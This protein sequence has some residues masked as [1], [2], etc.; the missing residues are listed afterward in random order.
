MNREELITL[1]A[2]ENFTPQKRK[3]QNFLINED[4]A[5]KIV[6]FLSPNY[7]NVIEVGPGLGA[8]TDELVPLTTNLTVIEIDRGF[9]RVLKAKHPELNIIV[10]DFLKFTVPRET[11]AVISNVPYYITTKII[12]KVLLETE[13][14][15]KFVFM[16]Q[17][18]VKDRLFAAPGTK[19][20]GPLRVLIS[21]LGTIEQKLIVTAD[22]FYPV[23]HV[24]SAVFAFV[25]TKKDFPTRKFYSFLNKTFQN[26][27][28]TLYNNLKDNYDKENIIAALQKHEI[29]E[30][31]RAEELTPEMLFKLCMTLTSK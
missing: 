11:K 23:P 14:L 4:I 7:D 12:E 18:D 15:E 25:R 19:A 2:K 5:R 28:K 26:R 27:R 31:V 21:L 20:Y 1:L 13:N 3:G 10:Q 29:S 9:A 22:K 30:N 16:T 24:D 8:L 17:I 6:S